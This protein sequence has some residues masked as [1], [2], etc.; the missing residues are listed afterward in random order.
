MS[1]G[2]VGEIAVRGGH[3][4]L[5]YWNKPDETAAAVRDG[6]MRTGDGGYLD[7]Q[8]YLYV[9]DRLKDMIITGGENVYSAEVENAV[10]CHPAV[11]QCA[12]IGVPDADWGE[13]VHAVIVLHPETTLTV[14]ELRVHTKTHIAGYKAPRSIEIV[15]ALPLSGAGKVIKSKLRDNYGSHADRHIN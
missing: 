13:R 6:W 8:G 10:V 7:E 11:A 14:D 12:V 3:V 5:G 2:A 15:K 9:V 4:M 1:S